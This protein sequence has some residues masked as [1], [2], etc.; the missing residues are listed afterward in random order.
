MILKGKRVLLNRPHI[1]K[2]PIE[3]TPEV[4]EKL[5]KDNFAKWTQLEVFDIGEE[6]TGINVGDK[7][8]ISK[9][10]I[11]HCEVIEIENNLKLMVNENQ[12]CL[13]W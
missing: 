6:V 11:E 7:V 10:G 3:L 9:S 4:Q 1:E 13:V 5:D 8:Y 12:I 2:S